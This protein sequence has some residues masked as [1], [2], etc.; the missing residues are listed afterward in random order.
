MFRLIGIDV[1]LGRNGWTKQNGAYVHF[2]RNNWLFLLD[3]LSKI[4]GINVQINRN[5]C[6][7]GPEWMKKTKW[8]ISKFFWNYLYLFD[9]LIQQSTSRYM[10]NLKQY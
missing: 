4:T 9:F 2:I 5:V 8:S 10:H 7:F 1:F 6:S 3:R